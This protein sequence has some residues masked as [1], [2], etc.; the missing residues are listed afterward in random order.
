[1][2]STDGCARQ[3]SVQ[4]DVF[5]KANAGVSSLADCRRLPEALRQGCEWRFDWFKDASFPT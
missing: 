3:F 2:S 4:P 5:G 1:M